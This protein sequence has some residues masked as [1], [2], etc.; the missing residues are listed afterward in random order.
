MQNRITL[1]RQSVT[2]IEDEAAF[3][4]IWMPGPFLPRKV[5]NSALPRMVRALTPAGFL[6]FG[7]FASRPNPLSQALSELSTI[8]SGGHPWQFDEL[9]EQLGAVGLRDIEHAAD[10][11]LANMVIAKRG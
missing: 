7:M 1:R 2:D 5:V 11:D 8:R 6:L 9:K 3:D 4:I 10:D